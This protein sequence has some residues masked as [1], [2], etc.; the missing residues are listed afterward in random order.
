M[1]VIFAIVI[2]LLTTAL[3]ETSSE[4]PGPKRDKTPPILTLPL[5]VGADPTEMSPET[6]ISFWN[7]A[8][9]DTCKAVPFA[10]MTKLLFPD[11]VKTPL[12]LT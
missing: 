10:V 9:L 4:F 7:K 5:A 8:L 12:D 2:L 1:V 11:R 3:L 6:V